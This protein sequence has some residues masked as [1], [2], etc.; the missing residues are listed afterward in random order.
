MPTFGKPDHTGRSSG[1]LAGR[2]R[3]AASLPKGTSFV[4][5]T[6][7]LFR[8][9]AWRA[10]SVYAR[11]LL[12]FLMI[13]HMQHAGQENGRLMATY[14]QLVG[15]GIPRK[16]VRAAL[17]ELE[18]LRLIERTKIGGRTEPSQ[19]RLTMFPA[20][21]RAPT[22]DWRRVTEAEALATETDAKNIRKAVKGRR[23]WISVTAKL[24][25]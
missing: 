11:R 18:N 7:D 23:S 22:N 25:E 2:A 19:Y 6:L 9:P 3:R 8:S 5:L 14:D 16:A 15:W 12:D 20:Y 13:E 4:Q 21:A 24:K 17:W 10:Q 1:V